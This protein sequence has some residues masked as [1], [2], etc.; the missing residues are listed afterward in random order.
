[1]RRE[2]LPENCWSGGGRYCMRTG[3]G[4]GGERYWL[5][6]VVGGG[7]KSRFCLRTVRVWMGA[8]VG[9]QAGIA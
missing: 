8:G 3:G 2:V 1:M 4:G 6:T 5:R 9:E 7:E